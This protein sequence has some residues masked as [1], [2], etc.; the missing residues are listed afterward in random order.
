M[1]HEVAAAFVV[2]DYSLRDHAIR[3]VREVDPST[4][5]AI[6]N[7]VLVYGDNLAPLNPSTWNY[8]VYRWMGE[9]WQMLVDLTKEGEDV[10]DLTLHAKLY[11][12]EP[13]TLEI[14]SV[15]VL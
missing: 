4:A 8:A 6:A 14:E 1:F 5:K 10:S 9:Y 15:H 12:S 3:G 11:D 13:P 7:S 2:G